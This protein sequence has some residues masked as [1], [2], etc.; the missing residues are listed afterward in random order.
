MSAQVAMIRQQYGIKPGE[1][2]PM[3]PVFALF[4]PAWDVY[5]RPG[6]ESQSTRKC[7]SQKDHHGYSGRAGEHEFWFARH[8]EPVSAL[9]STAVDPTALDSA[10]FDGRR[11]GFQRID[12]A[13][14][15]DCAQ[16]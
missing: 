12:G 1:D 2:L 7:G 5:G 9:L 11:S 13:N 4:N 14:A 16:R 10:N 6:Y 3:L 8:L 15:G